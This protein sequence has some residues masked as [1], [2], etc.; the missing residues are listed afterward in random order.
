MHSFRWRKRA[1]AA[2]A[3]GLVA[4]AAL[5]GGA[6]TGGAAATTLTVTLVSQPASVSSGGTVGYAATVANTGPTTVNQVSFIVETG[7][8]I[9]RASA[10][11][12]GLATC[13]QGPTAS[14]MLCT[15]SQLASLQK[16][17]VSVAFRV[18]ATSSNSSITATAKVTVS[19]QT[20]GSAGNQGTST[21]FADPVST[22]L[23]A[24]SDTSVSTF[25]LPRDSL[26]TGALLRTDIGLPSA[27]L[28]GH[29]GLA[30]SASEYSDEANRLC[31]KCPTVFSSVSIPAS[32]TAA[33]PFSASNPYSFI[34]TLAKD[35]Q[36]PGYKVAG[37]SHLADGLDPAVR[38][39]WVSVPLCTSATIVEPGPI[40][41]DEPPSKNKQTGVV[42]AR[43]RGYVNGYGGFD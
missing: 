42:T 23:L 29:F 10:V 20:Q 24:A 30:T 3:F 22:P 32:L 38:A 16:F 35:A 12:T 6:G 33:N 36:P 39:N 25:S 11:T 5:T 13:S 34:L 19:A 2:T 7:V 21:W 37:I 41:L 17:T 9:Y 14:S 26:A 31:D 8:G 40:C 27:F 1:F 18:P 4:L 15:T 28:N 43:G